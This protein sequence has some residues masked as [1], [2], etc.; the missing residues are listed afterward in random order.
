MRYLIQ[1]WS[2]IHESENDVN[3]PNDLSLPIQLEVSEVSDEQHLD[4]NDQ[5]EPVGEVKQLTEDERKRA[6]KVKIEK[7]R[8]T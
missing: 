2:L 8:I 1:E 7:E 3:D 6:Q 5:G 4:Q